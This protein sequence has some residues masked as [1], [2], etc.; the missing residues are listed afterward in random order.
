M[1]SGAVFRLIANDGK[2]DRMVT[3]TNLLNAR[4]KQIMCSR[5]KQGLLDPTPNLVDIERTHILF[6]N[7]HFKPYAAIG[8]EF[9]TVRSN[10]GQ[11]QWDQSLQFQI[12]QFGD[13]ISDMVFNVQLAQTSATVGTVPAFPPNIGNT[14]VTSSTTKSSS[15]D[16]VATNTLI[17]YT[18]EWVD[19]AGN[20]LTVGAPASNYVRY[21]EYPGERFFKKVKIEVNGNPLDD[22]PTETYPYYRKFCVA[23]NKLVGWKRLMG[24][25]VPVEGFSDF[26]TIAGTSNYDP[27]ITNKQDITGA[28]AAG[29]PVTSGLTSRSVVQVVSGP[30]TPQAV[31]PVLDLWIPLLFWFRDPR[32][33]IPSIAIPFGQRYINVEINSQ[34]KLLYTAP[35]NLFL[36]LTV[37]Q[38]TN[39]AAAPNAGTVNAQQVNNYKKFVTLTPSLASGSVIDKTQQISAMT[40]YIDNLFVNPEIHD[41]YI[42]R[43]GFSLI[44]V[45]R[46]QTQQLVNSSDKVLMSNFKWPIEYIMFGIQPAVNVSDANLNQHRDW[47]RFTLVNDNRVDVVANSQSRLVTDPATPFGSNT[48]TNVN[49]SSQQTAGSLTFPSYTETVNSLQV[50]VHGINVYQDYAFHFYRD[51]LSYTFGEANLNTPDDL[52][53]GIIIFCLYPNTYQ[54]SGHINTSRTRE[55]YLEY[56]SS[57]VSNS[58]PASLITIAKAI[59]FLLISDGSAVLRYN[60]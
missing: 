5:A 55:F 60:T 54:P 52:G 41:I 35:G 59:N 37:E 46:Y 32:L 21:C 39:V 45:H 38:Q 12:P 15:S 9:N 33:A 51:Y 22:Y 11:Q 56:K 20:V 3:A 42:K 28:A 47:H 17:T 31:Q 14:P 10:S 27:S 8:S 53:V 25:E 30:Q 50:V 36:R 13:F 23:P 7:A 16:V 40:L 49:L 1:S 57:Y 34:S 24:Q 2:A 44:R 19:R 58:T 6:V 48:S 18:Y 4:I 29:A 26:L 43:I